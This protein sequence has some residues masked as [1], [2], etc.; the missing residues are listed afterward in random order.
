MTSG[1]GRPRGPWRGGRDG[2]LR[3][4]GAEEGAVLGDGTDSPAA[5]DR[6]SRWPEGV[7]V[8]GDTREQAHVPAARHSAPAASASEPAVPP[9]VCECACVRV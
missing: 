9:C 7:E 1:W 6:P 8:S 3:P 2:G 5:V 4:R